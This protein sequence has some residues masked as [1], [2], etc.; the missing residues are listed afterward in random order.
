L[1]LVGSPEANSRRPPLK[2]DGLLNS[3]ARLTPPGFVEICVLAR[4]I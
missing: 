1:S 4:T 3:T 2:L